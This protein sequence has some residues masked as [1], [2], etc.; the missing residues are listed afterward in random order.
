MVER[1]N[2][3]NGQKEVLAEIESVRKIL[4]APKSMTLA[5]AVNV[6]KLTTQVPDV[7]EPWRLLKDFDNEK[8]QK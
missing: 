5:I 7:Y 2:T 3:E 1:L 8:K 4:T 6:D